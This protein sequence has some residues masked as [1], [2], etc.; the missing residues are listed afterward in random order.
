MARIK[1]SA[2]NYYERYN[3][4][5]N[6]KVGTIEYYKE[7][8]KLFG[9]SRNTEGLKRVREM[10]K[11]GLY[12][13]GKTF[14]QAVRDFENGIKYE[15]SIKERDYKILTG[16]YFEHKTNTYYE[17]YIKALKTMGFGNDVLN[18]LREHPDIVKSGALPPITVY[19]TPNESKTKH[20]SL[21]LDD[22][23]A[24]ELNIKEFLNDAYGA[25]F[26]IG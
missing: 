26:K 2:L 19:Y 4:V 21:N 14:S 12:K 5:K 10:R 17:N 24:W 6:M 16:Q 8:R 18:Y 9:L 13:K 7:V 11:E 20:Y 23:E 25:N 22:S 15:N 1:S 3:K